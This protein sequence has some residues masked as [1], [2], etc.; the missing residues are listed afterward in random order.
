MLRSHTAPVIYIH[1]SAEDNKIFSMS[2]DNTIK[3]FALLCFDVLSNA[4]SDREG[5]PFMFSFLSLEPLGPL[6]RRCS[7]GISFHGSAFE[8]ENRQAGEGQALRELSIPAVLLG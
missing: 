4:V 5:V 1:V 6:I 8:R 7:D 2:T 3:V